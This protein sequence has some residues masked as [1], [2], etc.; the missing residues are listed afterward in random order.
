MINQANVID[1]SEQSSH[2]PTVIKASSP[3]IWNDILFKKFGSVHAEPRSGTEFNAKITSILIG[4]T[5]LVQCKSTPACVSHDPNS[6]K[7][8]ETPEFILKAQIEGK[9][10]VTNGDKR[11]KLNAGDFLICDNKQSYVLDFDCDTSIISI[12]LSEKYIR[13]FTS[14]PSD[15]AF[16]TVSEDNPIRKIT[17]DYFN[18]LWRNR[19]AGMSNAVCEK[20]LSTFLEL[21]VLSISE[22]EGNAPTGAKTCQDLFKRCCAFIDNNLEDEELNSAAIANANGISLRHLQST[23]ANNGWTVRDYVSDQRLYKAKMLL[24]SS[25]HEGR[26]I[27]EIAYSTGY[28]SLAHFSRSFKAKYALSPSLLRH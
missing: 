27:S 8:G 18:S 13:Q 14:F 21:A 24:E 3:D 15:L 22:Q 5:P 17:F 4:E 26:T 25:L 12:P 10:Y 9:S 7:K 1:L 6:V 11:V 2:Q 23:F 16:S 20:L 19:Q 28:K